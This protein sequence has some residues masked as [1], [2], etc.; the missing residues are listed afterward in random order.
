MRCM[1]LAAAG[2]PAGKPGTR[3]SDKTL[4]TFRNLPPIFLPPPDHARRALFPL[5]FPRPRRY[6]PRRAVWTCSTPINFQ[7]EINVS[8]LMVEQGSGCRRAF[9]VGPAPH[10]GRKERAVQQLQQRPVFDAV[11][12]KEHVPLTGQINQLRRLVRVGENSTWARRARCGPLAGTAPPAPEFCAR[13][14]PQRGPLV[15]C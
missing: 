14:R 5:L 12:G 2:S 3:L 7:P 9:R 4:S 13:R 8:F 6:L 1:S 15:P 10:M 11:R